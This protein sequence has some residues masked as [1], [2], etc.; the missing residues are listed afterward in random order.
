METETKMVIKLNKC[1]KETIQ[2]TEKIFTQICDKYNT[3][4]GECPLFNSEGTCALC[5]LR[6][7]MDNFKLSYIGFDD[8]TTKGDNQ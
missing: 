7:G 3:C 2:L 5:A 8:S 1:E 4:T 6:Y